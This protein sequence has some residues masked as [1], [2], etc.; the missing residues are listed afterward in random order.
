[1][2]VLHAQMKLVMKR[3][4]IISFDLQPNRTYLNFREAIKSY[5]TWAR[6]TESTFAVVTE[7]NAK[8]VR[9]HLIQYLN[10][11]DRIFVMKTSGRLAWRNAIAGQ[12]WMKKFLPII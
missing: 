9:D 6:I 8:D 10:P 3:C 12:D 4:Y 5:G 7:L 11:D 1:M 2:H